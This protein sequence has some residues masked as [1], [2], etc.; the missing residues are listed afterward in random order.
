M[1]TTEGVTGIL[2]ATPSVGVLLSLELIDSSDKYQSS[3]AIFA[4]GEDERT[5]EVHAKL[6]LLVR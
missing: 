1:Q 3:A 4:D 2:S 6:F 5:V